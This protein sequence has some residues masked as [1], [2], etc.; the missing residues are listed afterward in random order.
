MEQNPA[1]V[2]ERYVIEGEDGSE[3]VLSNE[4]DKY[5]SVGVDKYV[6]IGVDKY[7]SIGVVEYRNYRCDEI[8]GLI[9]ENE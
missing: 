5:V 8:S 3:R 9:Y 1:S 2:L 6:S 4:V 7:I